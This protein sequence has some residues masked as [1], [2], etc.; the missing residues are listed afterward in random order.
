[1]TD[2]IE[3]PEMEDLR[4]PSYIAHGWMKLPK[5]LKV[6]MDTAHFGIFD[7]IPPMFSWEATKTKLSL[8][9]KWGTDITD[10]EV[11]LNND[12]KAEF[13]WVPTLRSQK[14]VHPPRDFNKYVRETYPG[15]CVQQHPTHTWEDNGTV[16][17]LFLSWN[18]T[19]Y[20]PGK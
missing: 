12:G 18:L 3:A 14:Y 1:M 11:P 13:C 9:F 19:K 4:I 20:Q 7:I 15:L 2:E 17:S 5:T 16:I 10:R 6:H 8:T